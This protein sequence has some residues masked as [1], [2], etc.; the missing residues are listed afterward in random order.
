M[1]ISY[2]KDIRKLTFRVLALRRGGNR[3]ILCFYILGMSLKK[4]RKHQYNWP[5]REKHFMKRTNTDPLSLQTTRT[6]TV[7]SLIQSTNNLS[8][9]IDGFWRLQDFQKDEHVR[10][11]RKLSCI[12]FKPYRVSFNL[13]LY[14]FCSRIKTELFDLFI[15]LILLLL[16]SLRSL[17][18]IFT[19]SLFFHETAKLF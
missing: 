15:Q 14:L 4:R 11:N 17:A 6:V 13:Y 10:R 3:K 8:N 2:R 12:Q 5:N 19:I 16:V 7:N 18:N 9:L 1:W